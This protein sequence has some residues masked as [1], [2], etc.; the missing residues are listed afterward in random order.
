MSLYATIMLPFVFG[1]IGFVEPCSMGIN[2][3]FLS[4]IDRTNPVRRFKEIAVFML[5][6]AL[7]L[8]LLGLSASFVGSKLFSFE[9]GFFVLLALFYISIGFLMIFSK[10]LLEKLRNVRT[11]HWLGLDFKEGAIKRLGLIAGLTIPA[12]A[13]PLIA[14]LLSQSLLL[15]NIITG[16]IALFV[17][18]LALTTPL[19]VFSFFK[20]GIIWLGWIA[21][22]AKKFRVAGGVILILIGIGTFFSGSYWNKALSF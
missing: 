14:V 21:E 18:G 9:R 13:I 10:S 1:L 6:R 4:S 16:F 12:C 19:A 3:M 8:A 17:F 7:V 11:A 5:V 15:G 22:R 20:R 2:I